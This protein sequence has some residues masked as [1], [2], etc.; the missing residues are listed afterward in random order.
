MLINTFKPYG[1]AK[2]G[3]VNYD[4]TK[5][6]ASHVTLYFFKSKEK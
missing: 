5:N 3:K 6:I 2:K 1:P 4:L